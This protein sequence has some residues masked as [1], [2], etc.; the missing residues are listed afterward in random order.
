MKLT[1]TTPLLVISAL[2]GLC[3]GQVRGGVRPLVKAGG[4]VNPRLV[5]IEKEELL[6][7]QEEM[8]KTAN[9]Q[10]TSHNKDKKKRNKRRHA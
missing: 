2:F 6:R 10:K 4:A 1:I 3:A 5:Q 7:M 8:R 9:N